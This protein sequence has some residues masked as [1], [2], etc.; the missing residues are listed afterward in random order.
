ME[1]TDQRGWLVFEG[2]GEGE[3]AWDLGAVPVQHGRQCA[4]A[5][6][7]TQ[8]PFCETERTKAVGGEDTLIGSQGQSG[9]IDVVHF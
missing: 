7:G 4:A 8:R 2:R 6:L 9:W 5:R 3:G 1:C